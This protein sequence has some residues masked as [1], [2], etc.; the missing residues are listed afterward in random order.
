MIMATTPKQS[1]R[2]KAKSVQNISS[3]AMAPAT[4][5]S[6]KKGGKMSMKKMGG[7]KC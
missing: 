4:P 2:D 3:K 7:K 1:P 6:M 5:A